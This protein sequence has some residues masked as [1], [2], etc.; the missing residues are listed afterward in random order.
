MPKTSMPWRRNEAAAVEITALAAGAGPPANKIAT[1]RIGRRARVA[2][3]EM[4]SSELMRCSK[5]G[6]FTLN[7][8]ILTL[9]AIGHGDNGTAQ[10]P[11]LGFD[12]R[13]GHIRRLGAVR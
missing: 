9:T 3:E 10:R 7:Q 8:L 6:I 13:T 4:D 2:F 1:R 11:R 5:S 12:F